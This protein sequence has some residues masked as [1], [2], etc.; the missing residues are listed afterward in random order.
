M[1]RFQQTSKSNEHQIKQ[2][3]CSIAQV[4]PIQVG[5]LGLEMDQLVNNLISYSTLNLPCDGSSVVVVD[6]YVRA[7]VDPKE[8]N[9]PLSN[10]MRDQ[11]DSYLLFVDNYI[12]GRESLFMGKMLRTI[13]EIHA[14]VRCM[15][16]P[17]IMVYSLNTGE[18]IVVAPVS[19]LIKIK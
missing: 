17:E 5:G 7:L 6:H 4:K 15:D 9:S 18:G 13:D 2:M 19:A 16:K 1:K 8:H 10:M 11:P 3:L 12:A 14:W